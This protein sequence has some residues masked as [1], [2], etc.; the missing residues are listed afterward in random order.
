MYSPPYSLLALQ[1]ILI[2]ILLVELWRRRK[3]QDQLAE[4]LRFETVLAHIAA[5]FSIAEDDNVDTPIANCLRDVCELF[6]VNWASVWQFE[7]ESGLLLQ[8]HVGP[9]EV[10]NPIAITPERF[11]GTF[12][13]MARGEVVIFADETERNHLKD[14]DAFREA[15]IKSF[16][17]IPL[18]SDQAIIRVLTLIGMSKST[19]WPSDIVT[20]LCTIADILGHVLARQRAANA[21]RESELLKGS[22]LE[23]LRSNA[24]V[25][26]NAGF[27]LEVNR[28]WSDFATENLL[29]ANQKGG[30]GINYLETYRNSSKSD[31]TVKA[32]AG[33]QSVLAGSQPD[34]EMEY[35]CDPPNKHRWL[36]MTVMRLIRPE[37]G[38]VISHVD[39][40]SQKLAELERQKIKEDVTQMNRA[41]EM[42]Q[43]AASLAH[44]LA[45]P[46]A[47]VLSNA[48][49]AS[50]LATNSPVDL[51]EIKSALADIIEDDQRAC[52]VLN[53][54]RSI[55]GKHT[56]AP[57]Q[58]NLNEIVEDAI[59]IVKSS[60]LMRGIHLELV[61]SDKPV[62]VQGD[63][64]PL[65][66]VLLNLI[67]NAMD[68]MAPSSAAR[69]VLTVRTS[70]QNGD[71]CGLLVVEDEGPGVPEELR[72]RL[73]TPFFTTKKEGLGMGLA[74][75]ST[76]LTRLGGTIVF[77]N[78]SDRGAAFQVGLPLASGEP[79]ASKSCDG[80]MWVTNEVR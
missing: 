24:C 69:K 37:G 21:L 27:I 28:S 64:I 72:A 16:L 34:F 31:D 47:A 52:A 5:T 80:N 23:S 68:A 79:A 11:P 39:I 62:L 25:I 46:L 70:I 29:Q 48:Q 33:M 58:V 3:S 19:S 20:R 77:Q 40:T 41:T 22:I 74:I 8:T 43:L 44:E 9:V 13:C 32:M 78:R 67:I 56:I 61:L 71:A 75:C 49:A 53:H 42:G 35:A 65:Q 55:L 54:V 59:L 45:Q 38:A 76:I 51:D 12:Q 26:D 14:S 36:R 50:R 60:A 57:H 73:F 63:E 18:R 17:A 15:G 30:V 2:V 6:C 66:Q 7:Q 1:M 4:R 10:A